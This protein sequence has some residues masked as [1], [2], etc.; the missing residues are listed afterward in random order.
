[1]AF[2]VTQYVLGR[3][4]LTPAVERLA[5]S[6]PPQCPRRRPP[7]RRPSSPRFTSF[8][9]KRIGAIVILF[10][11]A[12]LFW[13]GYEQAGIDADALR[14]SLHA[15]RAVRI[16]VSFVLVPDR[17]ADLR[18]PVCAALR[19]AVDPAGPARAV[20]AN[21]V[22]ARAAFHVAVLP[23]ARA[24][25]RHG[26]KRRGRAREPDVAGCRLR[27][28]ELGELCL[29]PV[30]LSAVTKFAPVRIL[31]LMMGVWFLS[32]SFG[33]KLA[34]S[35]AGYI[36]SMPLQTLFG[37]VAVVLAAPAVIMFAIARPMQGLMRHDPIRPNCS[38]EPWPSKSI[39]R[40]ATSKARPN[41]P[42]IRRSSPIGRRS[43]AGVGALLLRTETPRQPP[44]LRFPPR[45]QRCPAVVGR[46][47][48]TIARSE[49]QTPR[50][51]RRRSSLRVR[52]VRRRHPGWVWRWHRD[53]LGSGNVDAHR[54][55]MS[56]PH[57]RRAT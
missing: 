40:S 8:E 52:H 30:G 31:G 48:G 38:T 12:T 21:E 35:T 18:D 41:P 57:W 22:R 17:P 23:R 29:S 10:V 7:P 45:A 11:F 15:T 3:K 26:A 42:A 36:S 47:Q 28:S 43:R 32:N 1:M 34:G 27:D 24:R 53:A 56:T 13:G 4:R 51:A 14:R 19:L 54:L 50:D 20:G 5:H 49:N 2:G 39:D 25:G 46:A 55:T 37:V 16:L 33:N 44:A 9:W 6:D